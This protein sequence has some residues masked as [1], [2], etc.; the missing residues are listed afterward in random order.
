MTLIGNGIDQ[1]YVLAT[2]TTRN[3]SY[4]IWQV[5]KKQQ[6]Q[7]PQHAYKANKRKAVTQ[8][9]YKHFAL[10]WEQSWWT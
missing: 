7:A 6:K 5:S 2:H 1:E 3:M 9:I 4:R 8:A 10:L